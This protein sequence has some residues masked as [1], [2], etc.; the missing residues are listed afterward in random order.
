MPPFLKVYGK[1]DPATDAYTVSSKVLSLVAS[2]I[3]AGEFIGTVSA[4]YIGEKF[5]RK[6]GLYVS[7]TFIVLGTVIQTAGVEEGTLIV[8]RLLVGKLDP[9]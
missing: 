7:S 2:I 6:G 1:Y 4:F 8:G 9:L 3:N 5:G